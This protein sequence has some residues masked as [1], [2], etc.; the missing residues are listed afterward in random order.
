MLIFIFSEE[1]FWTCD[2]H[3]CLSALD[4]STLEQAKS[5][6]KAC[7][8]Q[9]ITERSAHEDRFQEQRIDPNV[10]STQRIA[11]HSERAVGHRERKYAPVPP[12]WAERL[13]GRRV[14]FQKGP[15]RVSEYPGEVGARDRSRVVTL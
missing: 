15:L 10:R 5:F 1:L 12:A 4:N 11:R 2:R 9:C 14:G 8:L 3:V 6:A 7:G 13:R